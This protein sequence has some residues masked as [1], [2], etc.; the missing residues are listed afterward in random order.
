MWVDGISHFFGQYLKVKFG[1]KYNIFD[2]AQCDYIFSEAIDSIDN[3]V[4]NSS[5]LLVS[6]ENRFNA[7]CISSK[8]YLS[9]EWLNKDEIEILG[10]RSIRIK[11]RWQYISHY[12]KEVNC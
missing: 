8:R 7:L 12:S 4:K 1:N 5:L 6:N 2:I 3:I 10:S 11:D 9:S